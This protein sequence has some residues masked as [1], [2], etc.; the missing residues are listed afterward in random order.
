MLRALPARESRQHA[1][2]HV[3]DTSQLSPGTVG[4]PQPRV[5]PPAPERFAL[6]LTIGKSTHDKLQYV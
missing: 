6:Q 5:K 2:G 4:T 3:R 1:P